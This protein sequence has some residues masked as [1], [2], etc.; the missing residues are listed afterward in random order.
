MP[1]L[2]LRVGL[3]VLGMKGYSTL[4]RS[5]EE[6]PR[7]QMHFNLIT[8]LPLFSRIL[9]SAR[10]IVNLFYAL[11]TWWKV[12]CISLPVYNLE[13]GTNLPYM[14]SEIVGNSRFFSLD[15]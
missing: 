4:P 11:P 14:Y 6:E 9:T 10:D 7:H 8:E 15:T 3:E 13:K 1:P 2:R 5:S 12:V